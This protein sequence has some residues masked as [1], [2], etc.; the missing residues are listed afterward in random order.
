MAQRHAKWEVRSNATSVYKKRAKGVGQL[1]NIGAGKCLLMTGSIYIAARISPPSRYEQRVPESR[2]PGCHP[3]ERKKKSLANDAGPRKGAWERW[4][5]VSNCR[6]EERAVSRRPHKDGPEGQESSHDRKT[7][8]R[9]G[10][11]DCV[12]APIA[13]EKEKKSGKAAATLR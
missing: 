7:D 10:R 8:R 13:T 6:T 5:P 1:N 4:L 3:A 9:W 2:P 11:D 12:I